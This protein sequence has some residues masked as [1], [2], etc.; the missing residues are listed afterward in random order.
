MKIYTKENI[1]ELI[2]MKWRCQ[3]FLDREVKRMFTNVF[4]KIRRES[5]ALNN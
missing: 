2:L 3:D 4:S 1:Q 5:K